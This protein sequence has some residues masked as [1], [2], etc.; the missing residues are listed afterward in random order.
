[1]ADGGGTPRA[2]IVQ[3]MPV[4]YGSLGSYRRSQTTG[5]ASAGVA[6]NSEVVQFRWTP[7]DKLCLVNKVVV[8]S[9]WS[10]TAAFTAGFGN[11]QMFVARSW[12]AD[13]SGGT[14]MSLA[15]E[16]GKVRLGSWMRQSAMVEGSGSLRYAASALTAGTKTLDTDPMAQAVFTASAA[17]TQILGKTIMLGEDTE[18]GGHPLVLA[19]NEGWVLRITVPATGTW[20]Y[21]F[22]TAWTEV[23]SY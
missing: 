14:V 13:G 18:V 2:L 20:S 3:P 11:M 7:G 9:L 10:N 1:M 22:M 12:S 15:G 17:N 23:V 4:D 16:L 6:A 19:T 5:I 8:E 21:G